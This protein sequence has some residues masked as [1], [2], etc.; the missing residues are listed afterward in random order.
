MNAD[1]GELLR[2]AASPPLG[3]LDY[4]WVDR[5][6][7]ERRRRRNLLRVVAASAATVAVVGVAGVVATSAPDDDNPVVVPTPAA[8][9]TATQAAPRTANRVAPAVRR[10]DSGVAM[11]LVLPDGSRVELS[12]PA[13]S[14]WEGMEANPYV[15][16]GLAGTAQLDVV[17][18]PG[19]LAWFAARGHR[20]AE[21]L[22]EPDR[23]VTLWE[24]RDIDG[25]RRYLVF[26]F[27]TWVVGVKDESMSDA[28]R[29]TFARSLH[30]S[31]ADGY[32]VLRTSAPLRFLGPEDGG[33]P[34]IQMVD[35]AR[36]GISVQRAACTRV[37]WDTGEGD[38]ANRASVCRPEWGVTVEVH[39]PRAF[40][41]AVLATLEVRPL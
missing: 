10:D 19:G 16:F 18:P 25:L 23:T 33:A 1:V 7:R 27:G 30:G 21:I 14:A 20:E 5:R 13:S 17:V 29:R 41:D 32:L 26:D 31:L 9:S 8:S 35:R 6:A 37:L 28:Q 2:R 22:A 12:L 11:P 38:P 34:L 3:P 39:G 40:V 15:G 24:V 36:R 4:D